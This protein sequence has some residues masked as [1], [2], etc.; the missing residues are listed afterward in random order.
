MCGW[1]LSRDSLEGIEDFDTGID[2]QSTRNTMGRKRGY[3]HIMAI[4]TD[5]DSSYISSS[6]EDHAYLG[7]DY[8]NRDWTAHF[9]G[10]YCNF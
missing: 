2:L 5:T 6:M 4:T 9:F 8:G 3:R 1:Q 7:V 10:I